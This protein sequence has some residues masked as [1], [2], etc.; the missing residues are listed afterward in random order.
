MQD[1]VMTIRNMAMDAF[2]IA[3]GMDMM[4][5]MKLVDFGGHPGNTRNGRNKTGKTYPH[6][7]DRQQARYAR[8]IAAGQIKFV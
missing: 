2:D 5:T 6:S 1:H 4:R 8:Q 3:H 7:S